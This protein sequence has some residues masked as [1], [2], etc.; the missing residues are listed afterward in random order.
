MF[1]FEKGTKERAHLNKEHLGTEKGTQWGQKGTFRKNEKERFGNEKRTFGSSVLF[2]L[3]DNEY[4]QKC[5]K[6]PR[7]FGKKKIGAQSELNFFMCV[8]QSLSF[9]VCEPEKMILLKN[10]CRSQS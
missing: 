6:K 2:A 7:F 8:N 5:I 3:Q 4:A 1:F 9:Y 10:T